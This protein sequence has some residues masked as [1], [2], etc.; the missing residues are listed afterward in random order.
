MCSHAEDDNPLLQSVGSKSELWKGS[1]SFS[2]RHL[3]HSCV[4]STD[5]MMSVSAAG[6]DP[7]NTDKMMAV[8]EARHDKLAAQ[9]VGTY[10]VCPL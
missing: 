2:R 10:K 4:G 1:C 6:S 5:K 9:P 8:C 3:M 7:L